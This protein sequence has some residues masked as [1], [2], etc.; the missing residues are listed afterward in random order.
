MEKIETTLDPQLSVIIVNFNVRHFLEQVLL[1]VRRASEGLR[2]EVIVVD[3]CSSDDSNDMVKRQFT[4]V[5][6]IENQINVGFSKANN[7]GI[8][9]A[10][11]KYVLLLNPDTVLAED[12]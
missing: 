9:V 3:N 11:G 6:L 1:S 12:T 4:E 10:R 2:V 8:L 7:Q 5:Y